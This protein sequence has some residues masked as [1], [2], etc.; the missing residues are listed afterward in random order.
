MPA[1]KLVA[2]I[3]RQLTT[4]Q[5]KAMDIR[6]NLLLDATLCTIQRPVDVQHD[7]VLACGR[8]KRSSPTA[9]TQ[10]AACSAVGIHRAWQYS[11][12]SFP[13]CWRPAAASPAPTPG[14]S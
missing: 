9:Q 4:A 14:T 3:G 7:D 12:L 6:N 11:A 13:V 2:L 10:A 1:V 5:S 8:D